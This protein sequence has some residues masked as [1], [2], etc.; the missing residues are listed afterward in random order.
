M[1]FAAEDI[2]E[3]PTLELLFSGSKDEV[4]SKTKVSEEEMLEQI[5]DLKISKSPGS[6]GTHSRVLKKPKYEVAEP[7]TE[8]CSVLLKRLLCQRV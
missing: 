5:D 4:L 3:I 7:R 2:G 8:I 1:I 6:D